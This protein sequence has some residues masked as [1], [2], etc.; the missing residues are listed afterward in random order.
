MQ[1]LQ[2]PVSWPSLARLTEVS[3]PAAQAR[4]PWAAHLEPAKSAQRSPR[5]CD[6]SAGCV[7]RQARRAP[8]RSHTPVTGRSQR[9]RDARVPDPAIRLPM[10][11]PGCADL[12]RPR[13]FLLASQISCRKNTMQ[14]R[15][16]QQRASGA[17]RG[18]RAPTSVPCRPA[19]ACKAQSTEGSS[20]VNSRIVWVGRIATPP[21]PWGTYKQ[22][23]RPLL[24]VLNRNGHN[25]RSPAR[26]SERARPHPHPH[27]QT[28]GWGRAWRM[29]VSQAPDPLP[30]CPRPASLP[31]PSLR[32]PRRARA[33]GPDLLQRCAL[34]L[35][36]A[37][38]TVMPLVSF[39]VSPRR[40]AAAAAMRQRDQTPRAAGD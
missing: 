25:T 9:A 5:G 32:R 28:K 7:L 40:R 4:V 20:Q 15:T 39:G 22:A 26:S 38:T 36:A 34:G 11:Q 33:Q 23:R 16:M 10:C 14:L 17:V 37:A 31:T 18:Q 3:R 12:F 1:T 19:V 2:H 30:C 8:A 29:R 13:C 6:G 35:L 27:P 21:M 24:Y